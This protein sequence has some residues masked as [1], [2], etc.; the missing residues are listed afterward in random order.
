MTDYLIKTPEADAQTARD[1]LDVTN[2]EPLREDPESAI[3]DAITA[4][5]HLA[6]AEGVNPFTMVR[7]AQQHFLSE[8]ELSE[9]QLRE[10]DIG[11]DWVQCTHASFTSGAS[12]PVDE[13]AFTKSAVD[14][15]RYIDAIAPRKR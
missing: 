1:M 12:E 13:H 14:G 4:F 10:G 9:D 3:T 6:E 2:L 8:R 5:L 15:T 11:R 7:M